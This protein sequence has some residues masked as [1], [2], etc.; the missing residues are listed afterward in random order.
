MEIVKAANEADIFLILI[1]DM[2]LAVLYISE[3][4]HFL[5]ENNALSFSHG[6][7]VH[8]KW[9]EPPKNIDVIM[10]APKGPG[11]RVRELYSEGFGKAALFTTR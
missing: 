3:I 10:V 11:Q 8:W 2:E 5:I 1:P 4:M 7:A 9:I 6:A